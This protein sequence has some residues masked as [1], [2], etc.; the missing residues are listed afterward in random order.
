MRI[1]WTVSGGK[2]MQRRR[3]RVLRNQLTFL[4]V[5]VPTRRPCY[6]LRTSV[7]VECYLASEHWIFPHGFFMQM[8]FLLMRNK[9]CSETGRNC[10]MPKNRSFTKRYT[11]SQGDMNKRSSPPFTKNTIASPALY[12]LP[13][14]LYRDDPDSFFIF[15][16]IKVERNNHTILTKND[17]LVPP[18]TDMWLFK[19][20]G[21][22]E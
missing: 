16:S 12:A 14:W 20:H 4:K 8:A 10:G 5:G 3:S 15:R 17:R 11:P 18:D 21:R 9:T 7:E 6:L 22:V 1:Y 2:L 13:L 19:K